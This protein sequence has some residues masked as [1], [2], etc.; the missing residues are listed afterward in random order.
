[1]N[2]I[3]II[4]GILLIIF[5]EQAFMFGRGW[6][7][8]GSKELGEPDSLPR[9]ML[10]FGR[11]WMVKDGTEPRKSVKYVGRFIGV[12]LVIIGLLGKF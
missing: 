7:F 10:M 8:K 4:L 5:P 6:M 2:I 11:G 9:K 12:V 1:M 3:I